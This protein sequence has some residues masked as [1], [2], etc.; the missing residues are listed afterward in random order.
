MKVV[1]TGAA[2][3]VGRALL[4]QLVRDGH[5]VIG[6]VRKP[7]QQALV[8]AAGA[9]PQ[10][11]DVLEPT[12]LAAA[13]QQADAVVHC[14]AKVGSGGR[15]EAFLRTNLEGTQTVARVAHECGVSRLI[16]LSTLRVFGLSPPHGSDESAA[17][18]AT[19]DPYGDSKLAA[20]RWLLDDAPSGLQVVILRPGYVYGDG[21]RDGDEHLI[22]PL[23]RALTRKRLRLAGDGSNRFDP[24]YAPD[25]A[26]FVSA[27]LQADLPASF[28]VNLTPSKPITARYFVEILAE[29][30]GLPGPRFVPRRAAELARNSWG[31]PS[32]SAAI[33]F[34]LLLLDRVFDRGLLERSF[35][36]SPTT[37][38]PVALRRALQRDPDASGGASDAT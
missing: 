25:L 24:L 15:Q 3:L 20:E 36:P 35:G 9:T 32:S 23:V 5:Q 10:L 30:L 27:A 28:S 14:A 1:V 4:S 8:Q 37:A 21:G 7:Q 33:L 34:D 11:G 6:L 38:L 17:Y 18:V 19:G 31:S 29:L 26:G 22:G 16:Q 13:C 2:G 12:S